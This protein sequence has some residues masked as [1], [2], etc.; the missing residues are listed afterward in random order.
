MEG[1]WIGALKYCGSTALAGFVGYT[2]YPQIIA[3][4]HLKNLTHSELFALMGLIVLATFGL[5]LAVINTSIKRGSGSKN[6]IK[7]KGSTIHGNVQAGN[8]N[9]YR[10]DK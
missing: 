6:S 2:V 8:N 4:S 7:I 9:T 10:N 1:F 3:S 5:C